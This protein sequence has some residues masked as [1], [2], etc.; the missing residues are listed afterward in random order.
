M[1]VTIDAVDGASAKDPF[2]RFNFIDGRHLPLGFFV[3]SVVPYED[4]TVDLG[5][6]P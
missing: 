6:G 2:V 4:E 1:N 3:F 5:H